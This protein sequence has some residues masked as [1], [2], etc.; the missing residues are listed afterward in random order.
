MC[1]GIPQSLRLWVS[2][3][4]YLLGGLIAR[5][6]TSDVIEKIP[7]WVLTILSIFL[8]IICNYGQKHLG[9]YGYSLRAAELFYDEFTVILWI[10]SLFLLFL[11]IDISVKFHAVIESFS[12]IS[13]GIFI[14]HPLVL[15]ASES[16]FVTKTT[17]QAIALW[18]GVLIISI[19][20]AYCIICIPYIKKLV[21]L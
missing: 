9:L 10:I 19:I 11:K 3:F 13:L 6:R 8:G 7:V 2:L 15:K 4:Y 14:I 21:K 12:K 20:S 16:I 5:I 1:I 17:P 18:G